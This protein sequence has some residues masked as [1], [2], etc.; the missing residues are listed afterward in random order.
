MSD[1]PVPYWVAYN[2][3]IRKHVVIES[4]TGDVVAERVTWDAAVKQAKRL[5]DRWIQREVELGRWDSIEGVQP[6]RKG[7]DQ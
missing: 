2:A 5:T 7:V 3:R 4:A 6:T 1:Q